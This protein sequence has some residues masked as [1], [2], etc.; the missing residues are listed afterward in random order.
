MTKPAEK[1]SGHPE[2]LHKQSII[3]DG[4][5]PLA[6]YKE[7]WQIY[8]QGGV[9]VIAGTINLPPELT[10]DT[11]RRVGNWIAK[12]RKNKDKM[13]QVTSVEDIFRA[14]KENKLGIIFHFQGSTPFETDVNN[15]EIFHRLGL[16]MV[17]L[18]Y[19]IKD[20]VGTGCA[21]RADSG[22]SA[23]GLKV[24]AELNRLGIVV[25]CAHTGYKTT[26]DAIEASKKPV[27]ISH[28]NPRAVCDSKRNYPDDIIKAIAK[29]GGVIGLN[30]YP[31]FVSKKQQ[32]SLDELIDHAEYVVK[33]VG[34]DHL[35]VGIDYFWAQE[36]VSTLEEATGFYNEHVKAGVWD[37]SVYNPPPLKYPK[38][39]EM[40]EKIGNL[41]L[42]LVKRGF[43]EEDVKKIM[44]LNIIRVF[45]E[46][47]GR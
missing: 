16:R 7:Y 11:I 14:K 2:N 40:P 23:F 29:K 41:T 4:T 1:K 37:A 15:V 28:G 21:E 20:F 36:G 33:L 30:G 17:Q 5:C 47:W 12:I 45:K 43:S 44:G 8:Y 46:V 31:D 9:T 25:D 38:G 19:N 18:T 34:I 26:M 3:I 22:L 39:I 27:I 6:N 35:S 32:S 13:L 42:A 24:V 10:R